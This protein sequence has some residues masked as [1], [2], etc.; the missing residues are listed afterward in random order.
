MVMVSQFVRRVVTTCAAFAVAA[1]VVGCDD[2]GNATHNQTSTPSQAAAADTLPAGL[3]LAQAPAGAKDVAAV[4]KGAKPGD[5]VVLRGRVGGSV[6]PFVDGRAS[7][8]V[9]D[10]SLKACGEGTVMDE[11]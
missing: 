1:G 9:V 10:A 5:E 2:R 3:V 6:S 4:K 11:C 7:F 8:Q